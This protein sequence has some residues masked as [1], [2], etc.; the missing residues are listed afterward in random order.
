MN[1]SRLRVSWV[2]CLL[3]LTFAS[4]ALAQQATIVGT[5]TDPSGA[6]VPNVALTITNTD[7]GLAQH[8]T[9]NNTGQYV[10][11]DLQIGHYKVRAEATGFKAAEQK[12]LTLAVGDRIRVD[13]KLELGSTQ[14]SI[15]VEASAIAVQ[16]DSGE[17]SDVITGQQ[18]SQLATN[19]RSL[20]SLAPLTAGASSYMSDFQSP[21]PVGEGP[22]VC[23][24][25]R[26][27]SRQTRYSILSMRCA[28]RSASREISRIR[29]SLGAF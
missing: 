7:T 4:V 20:Y 22:R 12:E 25:D 3:L 17:V 15:T 23:W 5:V 28:K 1:P 21:T 11:A 16:T 19:G 2:H 29:L 26:S 27:S 8:L 24:R 14:E 13:L 6:P 18:V 9:T 10:A